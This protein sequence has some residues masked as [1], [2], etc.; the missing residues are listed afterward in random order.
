MSLVLNEH[1]QSHASSRKTGVDIE[2]KERNY[3]NTPSGALTWMFSLDHKRIAVMY[4]AVMVGCCLIGI[5]LGL[6]LQTERFAPESGL[7][8][9]KNYQRMFTNHGLIMVVLVAIPAIPAVIGNFL[10]PIK[11]GLTGLPFP[12]MNLLGFYLYGL[13]IHVLIVAMIRG[14]ADTGWDLPLSLSVTSVGS[15][16]L[17]GVAILLSATSCILCSSNFIAALHLVDPESERS[18]PTQQQESL[19]VWSLYASSWVQLLALP[20]LCLYLWIMLGERALEMGFSPREIGGSTFYTEQLVAFFTNAILAIVLL[21]SIGVLCEVLS[22]HC[23]QPIAGRRAVIWSLVAIAISGL[24]GW[25]QQLTMGQQSGLTDTI[26]CL[27]SLLISIPLVV[28]VASWLVTLARSSVPWNASVLYAI[29][30]V[31]VMAIG[32]LSRQFLSALST[33]AFLQDTSFAV[34]SLHFLWGGSLFAFLAGL[35]HWW[36]KITGRSYSEPFG[37]LNAWLLF[38]GFNLAFLPQFLAG[39]QGLPRRIANYPEPFQVYQNISACGAWLI[40]ISLAMLIA[41]LLQSLY[42]G[43]PAERDPWEAKCS[44]WQLNSPPSWDNL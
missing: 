5:G 21:S 19:L 35:H 23:R 18:Q 10:I 36:P 16:S 22:V 37:V 9:V 4:L 26:F 15:V 42:Y 12:R 7:L 32:E 6:L 38:L 17:T 14:G 13:S 24:C 11:L 39:T 30:Y 2:P 40:G 3:L 33:R 41:Q 44:E 34:A 25:G 28:I 31:L 43:P 29:M 8:D 27:F 1:N 20:A